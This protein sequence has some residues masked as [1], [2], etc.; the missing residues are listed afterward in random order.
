[1]TRL[2][3][4]R[5]AF[6]FAFLVLLVSACGN[7]PAAP[8]P[9]SAAPTEDGGTVRDDGA[10]PTEDGGVTPIED[11]A[12]TPIEDSGI[13][14]PLEAPVVDIEIAASCDA[15]SPCGGDV[16]GTWAYTDGCVSVDFDRVREACPTAT[17]DAT[18]T[19]S[20][21]VVI[22]SF[23]VERESTVWT[24]A[25]IGLPASCAILG[26]AMMASLL[27][28]EGDA[29]CTDTS[30]GGCD[31]TLRNVTTSRQSDGY[32]LEGDSLITDDGEV[33]DYCRSGDTLLYGEREGT[34]VFELTPL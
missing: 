4:S 24:E 13:E 5:F 32:R 33:Y 2:S 34:D 1:M 16:L 29:T 11:G 9:D 6:L 28:T 17:V 20:G 21:I 25:E 15:L 3:T 26:C 10:M 14:P 27:A 30:S 31:C 22:D 7:D 12:V 8:G 18:A 19:A 23:D